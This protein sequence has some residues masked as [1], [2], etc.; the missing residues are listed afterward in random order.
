MRPS[1]S[2]PLGLSSAP[3]AT[4]IGDRR[5]LALGRP[6]GGPRPPVATALLDSSVPGSGRARLRRRRRPRRARP[7]PPLHPDDRLWRHPS[8]V[9]WTG[10][11]RRRRRPSPPRRPTRARQCRSRSPRWPPA[12]RARSS[13]G[14]SVRCSATAPPA[15]PAPAACRRPGASPR[16]AATRWPGACC[17]RWCRS[18]SQRPWST[19]PALGNAVV[20]DSTTWSTNAAV[21]AGAERR[22]TVLVADGTGPL[23]A[24]V[25]GIDPAHGGRRRRAS[26]RGHAADAADAPATPSTLALG[27]TCVGGS[28]PTAIAGTVEAF[29]RVT[30]S[31]AG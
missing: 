31:P 16:T 28:R 17:R 22:V 13:S 25:I 9:G 20:V 1:Q 18:R 5:H 4:K 15:R 26:A 6:D 27:G 30:A 12:W 8:E 7:R 11:R 19:A 21:V 29:G 24:R 23:A 14:V 2:S 10:Q 3:D